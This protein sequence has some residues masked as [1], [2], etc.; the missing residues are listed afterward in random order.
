ML[1]NPKIPLPAHIDH[2]VLNVENAIV[3]APIMIKVHQGIHLVGHGRIRRSF[4]TRAPIEPSVIQL[5]VGRMQS[6]MNVRLQGR[7]SV[8]L[9]EV[10]FLTSAS[11][12]QLMNLVQ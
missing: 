7:E 11:S 3:L 4:P 12:T 5:E 9:E 2:S 1:V 10:I 8:G 6:V